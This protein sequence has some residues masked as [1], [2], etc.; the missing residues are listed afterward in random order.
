M[1]ALK[2]LLVQYGQTTVGERGGPYTLDS[3]LAEERAEV[4]QLI[5]RNN[6]IPEQ[7]QPLPATCEEA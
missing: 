4:L 7:W 2:L 5:C 1:V 6:P 3:V